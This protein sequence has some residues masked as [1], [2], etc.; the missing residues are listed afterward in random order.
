ML[1]RAGCRVLPGVGVVG[2]CLEVGRTA[3][4]AGASGEREMK[5]D[6]E[7]FLRA[8]VRAGERAARKLAKMEKG[9]R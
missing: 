9:G 5:S 8:L 7:K 4:A 2:Y 3:L 6:Y 1:L